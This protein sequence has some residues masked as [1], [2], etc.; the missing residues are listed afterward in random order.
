M[1][2]YC[3]PGRTSCNLRRARDETAVHG[4]PWRRAP[5]RRRFTAGPGQGE[6]RMRALA[7]ADA[8]SFVSTSRSSG[9]W[10]YPGS[11]THERGVVAGTGCTYLCL[12]RLGK[13]SR[14]QADFGRLD[15]G[16]R[17]YSR[18]R[19]EACDWDAV[20]KHFKLPPL[21]LRRPWRACGGRAAG[22]LPTMAA[23]AVTHNWPSRP[24]PLFRVRQAHLCRT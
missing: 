11:P 9:T 19:G 10:T 17:T 12:R 20:K 6:P 13:G 3:S 7:G 16:L 5:S 2:V 21:S 8:H 18:G 22:Q 15:L 4:G 24:P 14:K 1:C 23:G